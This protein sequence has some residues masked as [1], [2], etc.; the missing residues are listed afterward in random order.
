MKVVAWTLWLCGDPFQLSRR[1]GIYLRL[2]YLQNSINDYQV[3]LLRARNVDYILKAEDVFM[4]QILHNNNLAQ[5]SLCVNLLSELARFRILLTTSSTWD[6]FLI[7]TFFPVALLLAEITWPYV[8]APTK[9]IGSYLL[10]RSKTAFPIMA[11]LIP[12]IWGASVD[13][14]YSTIIKI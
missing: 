1:P 3:N 6:N 9:L 7:A 11:L 4:H 12:D 14:D 5:Y 8:P 2:H 10:G 13:S